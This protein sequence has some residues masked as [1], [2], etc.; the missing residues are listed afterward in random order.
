M[1]GA[2]SMGSMALTTADKYAD[3]LDLQ[4]RSQSIA[5]STMQDMEGAADEV[6]AAMAANPALGETAPKPCPLSLS[7]S[8]VGRDAIPME[9]HG[10]H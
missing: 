4:T 1:P 5:P 3:G 10:P 9:L 7:S 8:P 2:H 6:A